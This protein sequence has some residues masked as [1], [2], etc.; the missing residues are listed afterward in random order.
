MQRVKMGGL[1]TKDGHVRHRLRL[2]RLF[3][4]SYPWNT[5]RINAFHSL[6]RIFR[7]RLDI[8]S[9]RQ[10]WFYNGPDEPDTP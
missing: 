6:N 8:S 4:H 5:A 10:S 7:I 3:W 2:S 1:Q 9:I